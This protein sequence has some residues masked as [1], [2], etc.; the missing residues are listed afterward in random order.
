MTA[1]ALSNSQQMQI[2]VAEH[3]NRMPT[4]TFGKSQHLERMWAAID[5]I[6]G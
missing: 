1:I 6:S 2:M 5:H 4:E 3:A